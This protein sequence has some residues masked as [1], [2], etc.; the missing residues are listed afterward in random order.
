VDHLLQP[1]TTFAH[2][3]A[4][5]ALLA[6]GQHSLVYTARD[7]R[8][9]REVVLK[10][11]HV[12]GPERATL[13]RRVEREA[14]ILGRIE[15]PALVRIW[16]VLTAE[17]GEPVLVLE[18]LRGRTLSVRMLESAIGLTMVHHILT[19]VLDALRAVHAAGVVH[20]DLHPG[21]IMMVDG[22][23]PTS[24]SPPDLRVIDF[25]L[26]RVQG[27]DTLT[28]GMELVGAPLY[29]AP[30]QWRRGPVDGRA[31]LYALGLLGLELLTGVRVVRA[32]DPV[33]QYEQHLQAARPRPTHTAA[34]EPIP[35]ALIDALVRACDPDR[36]RRFPDAGAMLDAMSAGASG[37]TATSAEEPS[38]GDEHTFVHEVD[39][40]ALDRVGDDDPGNTL[41]DPPAEMFADVSIG[42]PRPAA[43]PRVEPAFREDDEPTDLGPVSDAVLRG[44]FDEDEPTEAV[45][46][47]FLA[48]APGREDPTTPLDPVHADED[49][50]HGPGR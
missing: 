48:L 9:G 23:D 44:A 17:S 6:R 50:E 13:I 2:R 4:V 29:M 25:A 45:D 12:E 43:E 33:S 1:G 40:S 21:N 49:D 16:D 46:A 47:S 5:D 26:A 32:A 7:T 28:G 38:A 42:A 11:L 27:G 3:Y 34:G 14:R 15:H 10:C 41:P 30:E 24:P 18:R 31:D 22:P 20:R 35:P 19:A 36:G 8:L 37:S 39:I